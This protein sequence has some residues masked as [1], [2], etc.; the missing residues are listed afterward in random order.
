MNVASSS[1]HSRRAGRVENGLELLGLDREVGLV[2]AL[3]GGVL[4]TRGHLL[5]R[6]LGLTDGC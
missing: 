1:G 3:V 6:G 5:W 2:E 4:E